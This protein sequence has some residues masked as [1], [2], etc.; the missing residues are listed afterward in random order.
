MTG[1]P[2]LLNSVVISPEKQA[3][4]LKGLSSQIKGHPINV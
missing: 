2:A 4:A 3:L 1:K